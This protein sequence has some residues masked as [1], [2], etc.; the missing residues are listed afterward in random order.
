MSKTINEALE[1]AFDKLYDLTK[2]QFTIKNIT[3]AWDEYD[4]YNPTETT[5]TAYGILEFV[6]EENIQ[7]SGGELKVGDIVV[8]FKPEVTINIDDELQIVNDSDWYRIKKI[9]PDYATGGT[10]I[11]NECWCER[12]Q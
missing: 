5:S 7:E 9:L 8:Y 11:M 10:I 2:T 6:N 12:I 3:K 4:D 1:N